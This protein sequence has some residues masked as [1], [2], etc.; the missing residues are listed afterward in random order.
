ME[1][2]YIVVVDVKIAIRWVYQ[3][4][5]SVITKSFNKQRMEENLDI[6]DWELTPEELHKIDQIPQYRGSRGE[7]F[8]SANGPYKTLE[9]MWDGEI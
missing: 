9:E 2:D 6:F 5:V 4:G 3:Q 8:V 7:T 1:V